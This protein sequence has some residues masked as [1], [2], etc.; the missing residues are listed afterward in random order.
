MSFR[1]RTPPLTVALAVLLLAACQDLPE[2]TAPL[3]GPSFNAQAGAPPAHAR[4]DLAAWFA[5]AA[6]EV[7]ALP[8]TVFADHDEAGN[9]LVFGVE[10]LNVLRGV[11]NVLARQG[12]PTSAYR[13]QITQP[14]HFMSTTLRTE[15]RPAKGGLQIHWD[16]YVCTLGFNVDHGGGRSFITNSHC[17][18][19]Q[20]TT[21]ST[22][23][24]QPSRSASPTAIAQEAD[25]P[26]YSSALPG[27]SSGKTCRYSDAAR[28]LYINGTTS[29]L[30]EVAKTT[31]ENNGSLNVSG[32]FW[33]TGQDDASTSFNGG[34]HKV[35]R[36]TGWTSGNVT[37]TCATVNVSG[38]SIQLL[39]QTLVQRRGKAIVGGGDS[40]SPV[41]TR[42][43][44]DEVT[45]VGIL[46]GG[47]SSGDLFVFS[48]LS[49]VKRELG[50]FTARVSSP[51]GGDPPGGDEPAPCVPKG[52]KGNNCK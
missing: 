19:T 17:T 51:P 3:A 48:P 49:G 8:N 27:C 12:V 40:G 28:A 22:L 52:P 21:G 11:N 5:R 26:S 16:G 4:Q 33:I 35:G 13:V 43:S 14:I 38:S 24:N 20:G 39:C 1:T 50:S 7:M 6:P 29:S 15:H 9:M 18:T 42:G 41:F 45:L 34:M 44:G 23:Y 37:N 36:T 25:D 30:G 31:G 2:P 47:S 10:D 46:W 32:S